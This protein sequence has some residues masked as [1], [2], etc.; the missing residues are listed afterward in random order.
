MKKMMI[1]MLMLALSA[2]A[3]A[4]LINCDKLNWYAQDVEIDLGTLSQSVAKAKT[5]TKRKRGGSDYWPIEYR[6]YELRVPVTVVVTGTPYKCTRDAVTRTERLASNVTSDA[7]VFYELYQRIE[8]ERAKLTSFQAEDKQITVVMKESGFKV[9]RSRT[10]LAKDLAVGTLNS[11]AE[12]E[13]RR[14]EFG[15][16]PKY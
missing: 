16:Q 9:R 12:A 3:N 4:G 1:A 15:F 10:Q 11:L 2:T 14:T 5:K 13:N 6:A 7:D 8:K